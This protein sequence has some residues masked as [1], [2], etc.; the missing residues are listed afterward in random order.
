[1]F[2]YCLPFN[3]HSLLPASRVCDGEG[4]GEGQEQSNAS[5]KW[6]V[7]AV[8]CITGCSASGNTA[9]FCRTKNIY[10]DIGGKKQTSKMLSKVNSS[11]YSMG[12]T[13]MVLG[14]LF[15]CVP[16]MNRDGGRALS[17]TCGHWKM[18]CTGIC[19][20]EDVR[21]STVQYH[22]L[23]RESDWTGNSD[24]SFLMYSVRTPKVG[25][26]TGWLENPSICRFHGWGPVLLDE[27]PVLWK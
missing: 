26:F 20:A 13:V 9:Q 5:V 21:K 7:S 10:S 11:L 19:C 17:F 8:P 12:N 18:I 16:D 6:H 3:L 14:M 4:R 22:L 1:M 27:G 24:L 23:S 25:Q 2:L 15:V